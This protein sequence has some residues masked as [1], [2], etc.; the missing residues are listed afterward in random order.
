L[1][2]A[3]VSSLL[4]SVAGECLAL[5]QSCVR[6]LVRV[7]GGMSSFEEMQGIPLYRLRETLLPVLALRDMLALQHGA[8]DAPVTLVACQVG[9]SRFGIVVDDVD[10]TQEVVVKPVGRSVRQIGC[11]SGCTILGD[12][13]VVLILD[14]AGIAALGGIEAAELH[15][16]EA[17]ATVP[18]RVKRAPLLLF[19]GSESV[20]QAVPLSSIARL[21]EI[22][23]D[24]FESA[25]GRSVVQYRGVLLPVMG[26]T[27][28][29]SNTAGRTRS[30]IVFN[31]GSSS[32]GI[33]VNEIHDV[34]EDAVD[35]E[36][37]PS[38]PGVLGTAV[39][40]GRATEVLDV[41]YYFAQSRTA[42]VVS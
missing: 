8:T 29:G 14:P 5:P 27:P 37:A 1:T 28:I 22:Q 10:D 39:I 26:A 23:S 20:L 24:R 11:Y 35:L 15:A 30:V 41:S 7:P 13:R 42:R 4:V 16:S 32:F 21:E 12:G 9:A 31:D 19:E 34:V 18:E 3:I 33:A 38:R 40:A 36:F 25:D 2:L 6:E 17:Q